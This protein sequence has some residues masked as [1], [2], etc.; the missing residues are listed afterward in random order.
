MQYPVAFTVVVHVPNVPSDFMQTALPAPSPG[1]PVK[2][3]SPITCSV[4][5]GFVVPMPMLP[6]L[7]IVTLAAIL[8]INVRILQPVG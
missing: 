6:L 1:M 2:L 8:A 7:S 4:E 3:T 5:A